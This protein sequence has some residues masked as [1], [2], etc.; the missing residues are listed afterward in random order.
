MAVVGKYVAMPDA[1]LSLMEAL[2]HAGIA[3][4]A[5]VVIDTISAPHDLAPYLE[6]LAMDGTGCIHPDVASE[7]ECPLGSEVG[8]QIRF[9]DR[10]S[11]STRVS[12]LLNPNS[13]WAVNSG[14]RSGLP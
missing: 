7:L 14:L 11:P 10:T 6:L 4:D 8:Y 2:K 12:S 5:A 9:D 3:N 13:Y 1:Y